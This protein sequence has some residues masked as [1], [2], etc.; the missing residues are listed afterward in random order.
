MRSV[1]V[2]VI[3][4]VVGPLTGCR[5]TIITAPVPDAGPVVAEGEGE[6]GGGCPNAEL[7]ALS[8][9]V[10]DAAT[11]FTLCAEVTVA[12]TDDAFAEDAA[13]QGSGESC[14]HVVGR[15]RPGTYTVTV[16]G[17]GYATKIVDQLVVEP[18]ECDAPA[19]V[20]QLQIELS[21]G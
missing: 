11:R 14:R 3:A 13:R 10:I 7:P 4:L 15:G 20:S 9:Q 2:V 1:V 19:A 8:V 12:A 16:S 18:D 6:G 17:T 21:R 5:N